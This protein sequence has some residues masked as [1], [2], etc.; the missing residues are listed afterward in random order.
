MEADKCCNHLEASSVIEIVK[1][2]GVGLSLFV[3]VSVASADARS[4]CQKAIAEAKRVGLPT[5]MAAYTGPTPSKATLELERLIKKASELNNGPPS[6]D[7]M[8]K[9][10]FENVSRKQKGLEEIPYPEES[11]K[12]KIERLSKLRIVN[13]KICATTAP[14]QRIYNIFRFPSMPTF[15]LVM[16]DAKAAKASNNLPELKKQ[17]GMA[18]KLIKLAPRTSEVTERLRQMAFEQKYYVFLEKLS[19]E[20]PELAAQ[21]PQTFLAPLK[22]PSLDQM[23]QDEFF[24]IF[25]LYM[26]KPEDAWTTNHALTMPK[27]ARMLKI[28]T[29]TCREWA[30]A[31]PLLKG[32]KSGAELAKKY[33]IIQ[34]RITTFKYE[35]TELSHGPSPIIMNEKLDAR[36]KTRLKLLATW[37]GPKLS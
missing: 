12:D 25:A 34:H 18:R 19:K 15:G 33:K 7:E 16:E 27:D 5:T 21:I 30:M 3:W 26:V 24:A 8:I 37:P 11:E 22:K 29:K 6:L 14:R 4:D 13:A 17:L 31:Y 2:L 32:C 35:D 10:D 20:S 9:I 28:L 23:L 1:A 36:E